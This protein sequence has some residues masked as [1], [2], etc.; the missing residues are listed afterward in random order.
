MTVDNQEFQ[1]VKKK[2]DQDQMNSMEQAEILTKQRFLV[3]KTMG[4]AKVDTGYYETMYDRLLS[5]K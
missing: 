1:K 2:A 4:R 5:A 3:T